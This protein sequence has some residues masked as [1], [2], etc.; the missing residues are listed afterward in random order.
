MEQK[1]YKIEIHGQ[2][3][4]ASEYQ[5]KI[6]Q[7]IQFGTGNLIINAAAGSAKTTTIV[8]AI[9][10][11]P[12]T[13]KILFIAFNKDIV[14]K[15]KTSITHE[16]ATVLT[17]HSL[18]YYILVENRLINSE[19]STNN[20]I[21][22]EYKYKNYIKGN[23]E[24]LSQ[25]YDTLGK[26]KTLYINNIIKLVEYSRYYL[27]MTNKQ[28]EQVA[29]LYDIIPIKDE[30]EVCRKV[31][32][33]GKEHL[34]TIDYTDLLWL[35]NVLNLTTKKYLFNWIFIDEAQDTSIV[36]QQLVDKCFKRGTRFA[37]VMDE[38]Q[39]I[40]IWCGSTLDAIKNFALYSNTKEF[41]L[42]ISYR[43]PKKV[44]E[45]A[46]EYSDNIIALPDAI[47]GEINYD[48]SPNDPVAGDMVLCRT[49]APLVEQFLKYLRI[50]K[51]AY[52]RGFEN[53]KKEYLE[54]IS[55]T[56][57]KLIDRNCVTCDGLFP[58][59]Y[60]YLFNEMDRISSTFGLDE[61]DTLSHQTILTL[62]DNIESLKVLSEGLISTEELVDKINTIFNGDITNAVE[63]STVHKAK[64]LEADNVYIL[65]PS[66]MPNKFAKKEWEIKTEKNLIYVAYTR[67]KKTLNFI[68][69][70]RNAYRTSGYFDIAKMKNDLKNLKTT[71]NYNKENLITESNFKTEPIVNEIKKLG[72]NTTNSQTNNNTE[73]KKTKTQSKFRK[74]L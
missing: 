51:K 47:D 59:L 40:N 2:E 6:F 29:E 72:G 32:L 64:G 9:R 57:S 21:I 35:P 38:F 17:F 30:F 24:Q 70:D 56:H 53:I 39:Q 74:L 54:L 61:D 5:D 19:N 22:N 60:V 69:E 10:F 37:A 62:Y 73:T 25:Y 34:D 50:N 23:I 68:K 14:N 71:L 33:W 26:Y 18:G 20:D 12:E 42:P 27:A 8:N 44:V 11:I 66:L 3:F 67:A 65:Q 55:N 52:I 41:K 43:C 46:K 36:E 13:K 31:L 4:D 16:N 28:I 58:K 7:T 15:I 49:T 45:L 63:L 48:V 1:H